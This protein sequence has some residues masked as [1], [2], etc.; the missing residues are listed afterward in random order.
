MADDAARTD[1]SPTPAD[2]P[3]G[4]LGEAEAAFAR[5][6]YAAVRRLAQPLAAG[7]GPDATA[8]ADL[9]RRISVDPAQVG[10]LVGC[11]LFFIYIAWKYVF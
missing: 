8:A 3:Q 11:V 7:D 6:D 4:P 2:A 1:E 5:G 10:V 9:L